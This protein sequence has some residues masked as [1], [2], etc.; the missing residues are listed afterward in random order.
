M[1]VVQVVGAWPWLVGL[2]VS[3]GFLLSFSALRCETHWPG[4]WGLLRIK[5]GV[6]GAEVGVQARER[7]RE[8]REGGRE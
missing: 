4:S 1:A 2:Q 7:G 5:D 8:E 6:C 3:V